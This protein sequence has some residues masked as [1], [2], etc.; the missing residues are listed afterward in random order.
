MKTLIVSALA[1]IAATSANAV[2]LWD[3]TGI[4]N[5]Q[6]SRTTSMPAGRWTNNNA[7]PINLTS[8]AF[9]GDLG[10]NTNVKYVLADGAGAVQKIV[11]VFHTDI[12]L[13]TYAALVNWTIAPGA[14]FMIASMHETGTSTYRYSFPAPGTNQNGILGLSNANFTNYAR[15]TFQGLSNAEMSWRLE[16]SIVPEP[17]TMAALGLGVAAHLVRRRRA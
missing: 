2:V 7:Q 4:S 11:T 5:G 13:T 8:V 15:P 12:G 16:G 6:T 9:L 10:V 14:S 3:N 17:T 1:V